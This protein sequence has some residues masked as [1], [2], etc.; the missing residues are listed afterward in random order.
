MEERLDNGIKVKEKDTGEIFTIYN[1]IETNNQ[2]GLG[3]YLYIFEETIRIRPSFGLYRKEFE[4][5]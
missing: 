5:V 3:I 1:S 2:W 4:L